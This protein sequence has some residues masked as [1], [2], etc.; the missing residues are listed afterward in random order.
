MKE[1]SNGRLILVRHGES[2]GNRARRFTTSPEVPLTEL[3]RS[4][5]LQAA[6]T[7]ARLFR[8][9]LIMTSHLARACQTADII[10]SRTG[11]AIEI[12]PELRERSFGN[13][14]GHP[15]ELAQQMAV[16]SGAEPRFW[17]PPGG[18]SLE[19]VRRRVMPV[20]ERIALRFPADDVAIVSHGEV[21]MSLWGH[22]SG[23]FYTAPHPANGAIF[24]LEHRAGRFLPPKL[25]AD[26]VAP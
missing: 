13:L 20:F 10:A 7:I 9:Q 1:A 18:E 25:L 23:A 11:L 17:K 14:A 15:Y 24:V 19:E 16:A 3:G 4:Q 22:L 2:E 26:G 12:D 5:A 6:G 8:P 21:M